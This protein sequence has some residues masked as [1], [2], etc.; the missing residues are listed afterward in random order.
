MTQNKLM[1]KEGKVFFKDNFNFDTHLSGGE[2]WKNF[3]DTV[4]GMETIINTEL[5]IKEFDPSLTAV[6]NFANPEAFKA[7]VCPLGLEELRCVVHY[8][9]SN[10]Q[11]LIVAVR[12][13]QILLDNL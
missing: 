11:T 6:C 2:N 10:L 5:A 1:G 3:V 4:P 7:L 9:L 13:N 8:E 12:H